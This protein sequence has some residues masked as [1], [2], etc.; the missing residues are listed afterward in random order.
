MSPDEI[1]DLKKIQEKNELSDM[2]KKENIDPDQKKLIQEYIGFIERSTMG[3]KD[4]IIEH[5]GLV[6]LINSNELDFL[7][8]HNIN[9]TLAEDG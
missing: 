7:T 6:S 8:N 5:N 3:T 2:L 9:G 1:L 4:K